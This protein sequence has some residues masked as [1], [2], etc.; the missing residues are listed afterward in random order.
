M[1]SLS[2]IFE[3]V[4]LTDTT[5]ELEWESEGDSVES[6]FVKVIAVE[7]SQLFEKADYTK[8]HLHGKSMFTFALFIFIIY[9]IL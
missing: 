4:E 8:K 9:I 1:F 3:I 7:Y 6:Y 2:I 5:I